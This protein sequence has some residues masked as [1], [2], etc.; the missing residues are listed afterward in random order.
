VTTS[1]QQG[2]PAGMP[3]IND[4]AAGIDIGSRFHVA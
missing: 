4:H 1:R 2:K 3:I